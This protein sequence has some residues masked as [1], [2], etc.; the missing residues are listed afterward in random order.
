MKKESTSYCDRMR[1]LNWH[2]AY[3]TIAWTLSQAVATFG[4]KLVWP[5]SATLKIA[6][7]ALNVLV[8]LGMVL[9]LRRYLA[10]LDELHR[11]IQMDALAL[12]SGLG[13]VVGLAYATLDQ[14]DVIP[15]NAEIAHLVIFMSLTYAFGILTGNRRYQ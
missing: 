6:T 5:E 4:G 10:E 7:I 15:S 13:L 8:G 11:R 3:W 9:N 2:C 14:I 1:R 12:A